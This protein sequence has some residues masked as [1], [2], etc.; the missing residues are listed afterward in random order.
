MDVR[1]LVAFNLRRLRVAKGLS[2]DELALRAN[3]ERAYVG[4]LDRGS[5]NPTIITL[6]KLASAL[7]CPIHELF[8]PIAD[9]APEPAVLPRGRKA[10]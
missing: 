6:A 9:G 10:G 5:R 7:E 1:S 2:Q 3:V 8:L 4:H